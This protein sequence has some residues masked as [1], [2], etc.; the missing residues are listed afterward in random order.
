MKRA[1]VASF[2]LCCSMIIGTVAALAKP[3]V[4]T[5]EPAARIELDPRMSVGDSSVPV[6]LVL[7]ACGRSK[8]CSELVP[9]LHREVLGGRLRGKVRL[10]LRPY[11]PA[12]EERLACGR[13]MYAAAD[14]GMFWPYLLHL[15]EK[16]G[17]FKVCLL[18]KWGLLKGLDGDA[19]EI[20]YASARTMERLAAVRREATL[21]H[22]D[23]VPCAFVNGRRVNTKLSA[24]QLIELLEVTSARASQ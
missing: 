17:E 6:V 14:Q 7:Y 21:N 3:D 23:E 18:V 19:F 11:F 15:Y 8:T 13:A 9:R 24:D 22:V 2:G 16:Q 12:E 1:V 10:Y 20:A 5:Q 4:A